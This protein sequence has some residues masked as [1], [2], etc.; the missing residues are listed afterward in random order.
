[1][2][3]ELGM[4]KSNDALVIPETAAATTLLRTATT[5]KF[6]KEMQKEHPELNITSANLPHILALA[7]NQDIF[8]D[9]EN[10]LR[11]TDSDGTRVKNTNFDWLTTSKGTSYTKN[12]ITG[13]TYYDIDWKEFSMGANYKYELYAGNK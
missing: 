9:I 1:M 8:K 13:S 11:G 6:L 3:K 4:E 7:H 2:I 10:M 12:V 5:Y